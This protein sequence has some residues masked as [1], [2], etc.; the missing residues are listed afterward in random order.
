[1]NTLT[2]DKTSLSGQ[3]TAAGARLSAIAT[4]LGLKAEEGK[5]ISN[6]QVD[7]RIDQL[8]ALPGSAGSQVETDDDDDLGDG[9]QKQPVHSWEKKGAQIDARNKK[10]NK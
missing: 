3:L 8:L 10:L 6:E 9:G 2:E 5:N 7:A 4:R 1:M